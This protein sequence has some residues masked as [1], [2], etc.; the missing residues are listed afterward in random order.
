MPRWSSRMRRHGGGEAIQR[1][2]FEQTRM[3]ANAASILG[4]TEN[5]EAKETVEACIEYLRDNPLR[6]LNLPTE[7]YLETAMENADART[8]IAQPELPPMVGG[9]VD[10]PDMPTDWDPNREH[11]ED[12]RADEGHD[13]PPG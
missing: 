8:P 13:E 5:K 7:D 11:P 10:S 3:L 12:E 4:P 2:R 1:K 9:V 6:V